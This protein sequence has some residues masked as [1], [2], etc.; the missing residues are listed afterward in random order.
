MGEV[1][2]ARDP[3]LDRVVA[4][5]VLPARSS[6]HPEARQRFEREARAI[7]SLTHPHICTIYDVGEIDG[8]PYLV[9][10]LLEGETLAD[11]IARGPIPPSQ[12]ARFGAEICEALDAAHRRHIVHRDLKP[13]NVM[14]TRGGVKLLDFGLA[15]LRVDQSDS[16]PPDSP[17][18]RQLTNEGVI[19]GTLQY[20]APEQ[21]EGK[22]ADPRTDIFAAGVVMYEMI[23]GRRPFSGGSQA[24][25]AAAIV[26]SDPAPM[27]T[28]PALER[29]IR[30]CLAKDPDERWQTARDVALQLKSLSSV[31]SDESVPGPLPSRRRGWLMPVLAGLI[32]G[33]VITALAMTFL[34]PRNDA[35]APLQLSLNLP[36]DQALW[37][38]MADTPLALSADGT[39]VVYAASTASGAQLYLRDLRS[40]EITK[41]AGTENG[42]SPFFKPDGS[43]VGF[44]SNGRIKTI[45]LTTGAVVDHGSSEGPGR[46]GAWLEDGS[47]VW[48]GIP[49]AGMFRLWPA[50]NK[51]EKLTEPGPGDGGHIQP[52]ALPGGRYLLFAS[53]VEGKSFDEARIEVLDLQTKKRTLVFGGGSHPRFVPPGKLLFARG[54]TL[55]SVPF[56]VETLSVKGTPEEIVKPVLMQPG[57]GAAFYDVARNG[58]IVYVPYQRSMFDQ[59]LVWVDRAGKAEAMSLP[60][61]NYLAPRVSPNG[62]KL[63]VE[64]ESAN[65]DIWISDLTRGTFSRLTFEHENLTPVW[66]ADSQSVIFARYSKGMPNLHIIGADGTGTPR[67]IIPLSSNPMFVS[68]ASADGR[69]IAALAYATGQGWDIAVYPAGGGAK[70]HFTITTPFNEGPPDFSPDGRWITY[71]SDESGRDE[72]YV[73]P[74][75]GAGEKTAI[76][77]DGGTEPR[78]SADGREIFYRSGDRLMTVAVSTDGGF[79][80]SNARMLFERKSEPMKNSIAR[81]YDVTPDGQRFVFIERVVPEQPIRRMDVIVGGTP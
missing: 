26:H 24:S 17:T 68:S 34:R 75:E 16:L 53:E 77:T 58:N 55:M 39:R 2:R 31:T 28:Q 76:S 59:R 46:G 43:A 3:R 80:A 33:A 67:S 72:V 71:T 35:L 40:R 19:L 15:K 18:V 74:L 23:T 48:V 47:I 69:W 32:A 38:G 41:L 25:V 65:D 44:L 11:R 50:T 6:D 36:E 78:W 12:A 4:I 27:T 20:M 70:A 62:K 10:E 9:M 63:L 8:R 22:A 37:M 64:I 30:P 79:S 7:S 54:D 49:N 42:S 60:P 29:I 66:T 1:Y 51:R 13:G 61:R 5:K 56:D 14:I 81:N 21:V 73:Q 52:S 45:T 57:T